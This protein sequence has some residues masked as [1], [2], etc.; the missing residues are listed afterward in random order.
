VL[1]YIPSFFALAVILL[2]YGLQ[3]AWR[4]RPIWLRVF[5][6]EEEASTDILSA[7]ESGED[8]C[9]DGPSRPKR[10]LWSGWSGL[11]FF[12]ALVGVG[13]GAG[14]P[15]HG[16][17]GAGF[18]TLFL[19]SLIC[20]VIIA[21]ERPVT[22]SGPVFLIQ[23]VTLLDQLAILAS[24]PHLQR[25]ERLGFWIAT[26]Y[27]PALSLL[28]LLVMPLNTTPSLHTAT[29]SS[30]THV[31]EA[32]PVSAVGS[33]P[34]SSER[35]PEDNLSLWQWM[36]VS[37]M[38]PLISLA[39]KARLDDK[40]VWYLPL[41]FQH[42]R[43][44]LRF[45]EV[46]GSVIA[47]LFKA[48]GVDLI[49][50][51]CLG[52]LESGMAL[53]QIPLLKQLLGAVERDG[54]MG[55]TAG[56]VVAVRYAALILVARLIAAQSGVFSLW[57]QRRCYERSRGEMITMIY[58]KTLR[59]KAFAEA[60]DTKPQEKLPAGAGG[61]GDDDLSDDTNETRIDSSDPD[62]TGIVSSSSD[63]EALAKPSSKSLLRRV[64]ALLT[65]P[66]FSSLRYN[67]LSA[68]QPIKPAP[69]KSDS[70]S[71]GKI[72]NILRSDVYEVAQRFWE[73]ASLFTKPLNVI[74]SLVLIWQI[75][76]RASLLGILI[77]IG[78]MFLVSV[79]YRIQ[80]SLETR[81]RQVTDKKL[82]LTA[83]FVQ[84]LRHLR[85][86]AW[87][88]AWLDQILTE[89][90]RELKLRII[91]S[92]LGDLTKAVS[93]LATYM[94]PV[95]AFMAYTLLEGRPLRVEIAFPA[96]NLF[97][98]L[99]SNLQDLPNLLEALLKASIA[100]KR[101]E[102]FMAEPEVEGVGE[103]DLFSTHVGPL[104]PL[105]VEMKDAS[106]SWP[107]SSRVVLKDVSFRCEPGLTLIAGKT[108]IGK[109][110][111]LHAVL[112]EMESLSGERNVP[113]EVLGYCA[114][115]PWLQLMS[116]RDNVLFSDVAK[117]DEARYRQ[118][119]E[120]CCLNEMFEEFRDKG[121]E[122]F[123][124]GENS[125]GLSGGQKARVALARA[126]YSRA[127]ILL[128]DDP[129][130]ALDHGT[131]EKVMSRLFGPGSSLMR[132]RI[133]LFASHRT[134]LFRSY[135][136][137]VLE[138]GEG[139]TVTTIER[140]GL[141]NWFK[142][143]S[144]ES[145]PAPQSSLMEEIPE[146]Q[147]KGLLIEAPP[148]T[149]ETSATMIE[150]KKITEEESRSDNS[151]MW[152]IYWRYIRAGKWY[153]WVAVIAFFIAFRGA[154][155]GY[156]WYLKVWSEAYQPDFQSG[157][158][159]V[160]QSEKQLNFGLPTLLTKPG[161]D[162]AAVVFDHAK[163]IAANATG[164]AVGSW[165]DLKLPS[166]LEDVKPWLFWFAIIS[167]VQ[168]VAR[169]LSNASLILVVWSAGK[170][171]YA[172]L[173]RSV[174]GATF[175]WYD[176]TTSGSIMNRMTS[177]IGTIDG[178]IAG[179]L[180]Q[181]TYQAVSWLSAVAVIAVQTPIFL[182]LTVVMT[183]LFVWVFA[184]FLPTSLGLRKLE[185]VSL[186]PLMLNFGA[187]IQGLVTVRAFR[188]Q[189]HFQERIVQ[190]TDAFQKP[191]HFYWSVQ[192][193]LSY[194]FDIL[195][196]L[197]TFALTLTALYSGLS[198]GAVGF[199]LAAAAT[200]VDTTH[201]MCRKYGDLQMNFA[202][203][204]RVIEYLDLPQE[205]TGSPPPT[206][207]PGPKDDIILSHVTLRYKPDNPAVLK[208][209]SFRIPA[210]ST[211]AVTGQSGSGKST[212]ALTLLGTMLPDADSGGRVRIGNVDVAC[213]DK[214]ALRRKITFVA[215]DPVLFPGTLR[216][217]LDPLMEHT[218]EE[219]ETVLNR[220]FEHD[221]RAE[222]TTVEAV[223]IGI[224]TPIAGGDKTKLSF[225]QK[226]LVGLARAVLRRS[227]IV[228]L[229]EVSHRTHLD[230]LVCRYCSLT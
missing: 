168:V 107:G 137:Q 205:P 83:Q 131:A 9:L 22:N 108:A 24:T 221:E 61:E 197:S 223:R 81:R 122:H 55:K 8:G 11:L 206:D 99:D 110:A 36:T 33:P 134:D 160:G 121:G 196:A 124:I 2:R 153:W 39:R 227:P 102:A 98:L 176:R 189:P 60:S 187:L 133:V 109:S 71:T 63:E 25:G 88:G 191:D 194:R 142:S 161:E 185:M 190:T 56:L 92:F 136:S 28:I 147:A 80:M 181:V 116:L 202:S 149:D 59:R 41:Q 7:D 97:T 188:A 127:R 12:V 126:V 180:V 74:L 70:S 84:N 35:S 226:Q 183:A 216:E 89:R 151:A 38:A 212:L 213:V 53:I 75:L 112:G 93:L 141:R 159:I 18:A 48:N 186:S 163:Q 154:N 52:L 152:S 77:I 171:L 182:G 207:W 57:Y 16:R 148:T 164:G 224:D 184:W 157:P 29:L 218:D 78:A 1:V 69:A 211:V 104:E 119:V 72:Q 140:N 46:T 76:G 156:F 150:A 115:S 117:P 208:D 219:C 86:Y 172:Q 32:H 45:R 73:F 14:L 13:L 214:D 94:F 66:N 175:Q 145:S 49:I 217:N 101:I 68:K 95:A 105:E 82:G 225:G 195:S 96:L 178:Q 64:F 139:G 130:A 165:F 132:G 42:D 23:A 228:I 222:A 44:H 200:F 10:K 229:D 17:L 210:G 40:D 5:A 91:S 192:A 118:V 62:M 135:T 27:P 30:P 203:V 43:L 100:M 201:Q 106:F 15:W 4:R 167:I 193:W 19:P 209:V 179:I 67:R 123:E 34:S 6:A 146:E 50:I 125:I 51:A 31:P 79:I 144:R 113:E 120:A 220:V 54:G 114:Q 111:L 173:M 155:T 58:E 162:A 103:K 3:P 215:Q 170:V 143:H 174:A 230:P 90:Q 128:L 166:P 47:R 85:W 20:G 129:V 169:I 65:A 37:W 21:I 87:T 138:I 158:A 26:L 177:D 199:V 198:G 204:Q